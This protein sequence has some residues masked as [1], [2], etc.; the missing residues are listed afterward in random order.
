MNKFSGD[1]VHRGMPM[2][3]GG[4]KLKLKGRRVNAHITI[5]LFANNM[6]AVAYMSKV[7]LANSGCESVTTFHSNLY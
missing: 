1:V 5:R 7:R 2:H 6:R 4:I 3:T